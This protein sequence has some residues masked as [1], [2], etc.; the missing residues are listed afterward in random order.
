[1]VVLMDFLL[2][3][4]EKHEAASLPLPF[5]TNPKLRLAYSWYSRVI[6]RNL[7]SYKKK[8][9]VTVSMCISDN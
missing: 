2:L 1:M 8:V 7:H 4:K 3:H 6:I 5:Q 9:P